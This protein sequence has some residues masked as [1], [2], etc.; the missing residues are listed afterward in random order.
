MELAKL[1]V[2]LKRFRLWS[3][4]RE[5]T[6]SW[7]FEG[8]GTAGKGG[9][10]SRIVDPLGKFEACEF[11][12]RSEYLVLALQIMTVAELL[13]LAAKTSELEPVAVRQDTRG[14]LADSSAEAASCRCPDRGRFLAGTGKA[15]AHRHAPFLPGQINAL[16][17]QFRLWLVSHVG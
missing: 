12:A 17:A 1:Q 10:I 2:E 8:R 6:S 16:G 7:V 3:K 5:H 11:E 4:P 15:G 13:R 9:V 14:K